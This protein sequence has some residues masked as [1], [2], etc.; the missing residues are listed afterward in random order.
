M[1]NFKIKNCS[2]QFRKYYQIYFKNK[3]LF[4]FIIDLGEWGLGIQYLA[5]CPCF[6]FLF[7]CFRIEV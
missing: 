5:D 6:E 7:L 2:N 1:K 3:M 4:G